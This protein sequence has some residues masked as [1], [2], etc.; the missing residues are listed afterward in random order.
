MHVSFFS[1]TNAVPFVMTHYLFHLLSR[2]SDLHI[3]GEGGGRL[4]GMCVR[5]HSVALRSPNPQKVVIVGASVHIAW[6][7]RERLALWASW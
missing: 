1:V 3:N 4:G 6:A 2:E 7:A 5:G